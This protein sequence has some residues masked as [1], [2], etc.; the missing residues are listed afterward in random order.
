MKA[1]ARWLCL[2]LALTQW[3]CKSTRSQLQETATV[4]SQSFV[5]VKDGQLWADGK[6]FRFFGSNFYRLALADAFG[7]QV[8][9]ETANGKIV[10]PQIEKVMEN[11]AS[12][13]IRVVRLWTF[14]CEGSRGS[15]VDPP[16]L[17][18]DFTLNQKGLRQLD[19]TIA[20]AA[21]HG[22]KIIFPLVN[23]EHEYCG[24]EWWVEN[25]EAQASA[26]DKARFVKS[27]V[28][29]SNKPKILV[30]ANQ[31]C[32]TGLQAAPT[33]ELFYTEPTVKSKF[34]DYVQE[35]LTRSNSYTGLALRDDPT[36]L[37]VELS[38]EP[39]TSDYYECMASAVGSKT[40]D[41]CYE[42]MQKGIY[43]NYKAG[44]LV[45]QWLS[46]MGSFV[47]G[48][49]RNHLVAS[50]EEA[51]RS[52]H[53]DFKCLEKHSWIN[54]GSK[55][56]DFARNATIPS[57]DMMSTH[58]YPDNWAIPV[59]DLDWFYDCVIKDRARLARENGKP[60]YMEESGFSEIPYAGKPDTYIKNRPYYLSRMFSMATQAGYQGVMVWQAAPLTV[61]GKVA[62][63]DAFT[64]P[65]LTR[66]DG[67][68]Q[69]SPEGY[70]VRQ[71]VE[72]VKKLNE[73]GSPRDCVPLCPPSLTTDT[74]KELIQAD[75]TRCFALSLTSNA[76]GLPIGY[77]KCPTGQ[78]RDASGWGWIADE[79]LCNQFKDSKAQFDTKK[80]CSC[81]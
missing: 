10:Y 6:P 32:P 15:R 71:Q 42:D 81:S 73:G 35:M 17:N 14:A 39:H 23:F 45:Y 28:D 78:V 36:V 53:Q 19:F 56:V 65:I 43:G 4:R 60:I 54:N 52:S 59:D 44:T 77:P 50:G 40:L 72:C 1:L 7:A 21:R 27:C 63:D 79:A 16:I 70:A 34:K 38:N 80:A 62:E 8:V 55:G 51:Y 47:K 5:S 3:Q 67:V 46:E 20:S 41:S 29:S 9:Q 37:A 48:L 49:D 26:S 18:K 76:Q 31:S 66:K 61:D 13:G 2:G 11:Y 68:N 69:Y 12:E 33:K 57:L 75:G 30:A 25:T 22:I 74:P 64:F 58:L 24:M